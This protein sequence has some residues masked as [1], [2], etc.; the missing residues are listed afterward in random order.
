MTTRETQARKEKITKKRALNRLMALD[1]IKMKN[2]WETVARKLYEIL[3]DV[4]LNSKVD[5]KSKLIEVFTPQKNNRLPGRKPSVFPWSTKDV[6]VPHCISIKEK[7]N[8]KTNIGAARFAIEL[9]SKRGN[10]KIEA[11]KAET[12]AINTAKRMSEQIKK[13]RN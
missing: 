7:R 12:I 4:D 9:A 11:S 1:E 2:D 10:L 13:I 3:Q 5:I 8:I 6:W